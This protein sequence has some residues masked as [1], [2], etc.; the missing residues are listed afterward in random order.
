MGVPV[1]TLKGDTFVSRQGFAILK[2][3]GLDTFVAEDEQA[4]VTH[5]CHFASHLEEL[6]QVRA[7][8]R[9]RMMASPML[10][11]GRYAR[12]LSHALTTIHRHWRAQGDSGAIDV[13]SSTCEPKA[14]AMTA[15]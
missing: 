8:L 2:R 6:A 3:V 1:V 9:H 4:F 13:G 10:D 7:E 11:P 5:A 12:E 15:H 14:Q